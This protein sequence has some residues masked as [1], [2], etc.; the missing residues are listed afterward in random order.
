M[1]QELRSTYRPEIVYAKAGEQVRVVSDRGNVLIVEKMDRSYRFAVNKSL[2][3]D[4]KENTEAAPDTA[5]PAKTIIH[6][7]PVS[8]S[9]AAPKKQNTLF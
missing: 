4:K 9:K 7:A 1:K 6:R 5:V 8:K 2:L 3:T